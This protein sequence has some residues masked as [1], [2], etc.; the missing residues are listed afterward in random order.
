MHLFFDTETSGFPSKTLAP[1][2]PKQAWIVQFA[3][4]LG[5]EETIFSQGSFIIKAQGRTIHPG[6]AQVHGLTTFIADL[7]GITEYSLAEVISDLLKVSSLNIC[8]NFPFD[9]QMVDN[10]LARNGFDVKLNQFP[11][12]CTMK[13]ST[14]LCKI[15][16]PKHGGNKW[17]KLEELHRFLFNEEFEGT[18]DALADVRA[19]RRCYYELIKRLEPA[20]VVA[21]DSAAKEG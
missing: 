5:S 12:Y 17:P 13:N 7:V 11:N 21:E 1:S 8:H 14:N 15:P 3:Y 4:I 2:D 9:S 20:E 10:L 19:T 6:A 18:H 16:H